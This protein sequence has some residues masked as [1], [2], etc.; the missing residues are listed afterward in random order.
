MPLK[1]QVTLKVFSKWEI[2]FVGPNNQPTR[3]LGERYIIT[4]KKYLTIWAEAS[5]VKY[6][7]V[8]M[9]TQF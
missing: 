9:T 1:P 3:R 6:C 7:S 5:T 2:E 8:D 4:V